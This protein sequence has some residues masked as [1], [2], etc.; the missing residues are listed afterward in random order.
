MLK[1]AKLM[2]LVLFLSVGIVQTAGADVF[3]Q[4]DWSGGSGQQVFRDTTMYLSGENINGWRAP[5]DLKL[6]A[7]KFPMVTITGKIGGWAYFFA[8]DQSGAIYF[9]AGGPEVKSTDFGVT[10][11]TLPTPPLASGMCGILITRDQ[12]VWL[13]CVWHKP[14][15]CYFSTDEGLTWDSTSTIPVPDTM[16]QYATPCIE[17]EDGTIFVTAQPPNAGSTNRPFVWKT[18]NQGSTWIQCGTIAGEAYGLGEGRHLIRVGDTLYLGFRDYPNV[19]DGAIF[20]ST[21]WGVSWN[22]VW[23]STIGEAHVLLGTRAG[24]ILNGT[25]NTGYIYRS[26]DG[27]A[28][29]VRTNHPNVGVVATM[30]QADDGTIYAGGAHWQGIYKSTDDGA[31]WSYQSSQPQDF[32][33]SMMQASDGTIY[34]GGADY[35][36]TTKVHKAGF[37]PNGY[38]ESSVFEAGDSNEWGVMSWIG[39]PQDTIKMKVRTSNDS[40]MSGATPWPDCPLVINGQD[41]SGLSSVHDGDRYIQYRAELASPSPLFVTPCLHE[42]TIEYLASRVTINLV[43]DNDTIPRGGV[44]GFTVTITNSTADTQQV[45][46]WTEAYLPDGSPYPKNPVLGPRTVTLKPNQTI[47]RHRNHKVPN[48][49]PLGTYKYCG[50]VG[51]YPTPVMDEDCFLFTV[52]P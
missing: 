22:I 42:V 28:S 25:H 41:I 36:Y 40:L 48:N 33:W 15:I 4:T 2:G 34:F 49:A 21:D 23:Q 31:T 39:E 43:A 27:G 51:T 5:G 14:P 7:P 52:T 9:D 29:W 3:R 16:Y 50:K 37:F 32:I 24:S 6:A 18:T 8:E 11:D 45:Q 44:L 30:I 46:V 35:S 12:S 10:W 13:G 19:Y 20:K 47:T 38:L 17:R 26:T 1:G